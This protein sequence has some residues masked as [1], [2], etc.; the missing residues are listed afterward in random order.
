MGSHF[1]FSDVNVEGQD[2]DSIWELNESTLVHQPEAVCDTTITS[3][4]E[5]TTL[6]NVDALITDLDSI[7]NDQTVHIPDFPNFSVSSTT[8][9]IEGNTYEEPMETS[10]SSVSAEYISHLVSNLRE[11]I[12]LSELF[13]SPPSS[14]DISS[15]FSPGSSPPYIPF[16]PQDTNP[17]DSLMAQ[18]AQL[19]Y[20]HIPITEATGNMSTAPAPTFPEP[21]QIVTCPVS[22]TISI[23]CSMV[24]SPASSTSLA[25]QEYKEMRNKNNE[26]CVKYRQRLNRTKKAQEEELKQLQDKNLTLKQELDVKQQMVREYRKMVKAML[27]TPQTSNNPTLTPTQSHNQHNPETT[28]NLSQTNFNLRELLQEAN[29]SENLLD[30]SEEQHIP[31]NILSECLDCILGSCSIHS[32]KTGE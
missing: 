10:Q 17:E 15:L 21:T 25:D 32:V 7:T 18:Q 5:L 13:Q 23:P 4:V 2:I 8:S 31:E 1:D 24:D 11:P 26:A 12:P 28:A 6:Q 27:R 20:I 3:S 22:Y 29:L 30:V 14:M 9:P 16:S 19:P